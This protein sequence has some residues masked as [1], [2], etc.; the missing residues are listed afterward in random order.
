MIKKNRTLDHIEKLYNSFT[1]KDM[2]LK[3]FR[4]R[5]LTATD[6]KKLQDDLHKVVGYRQVQQTQELVAQRQK[7]AI[8]SR[9]IKN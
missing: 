6:P 1:R 2:T 9:L 4:R 8:D 7:K 3:E 5:Y